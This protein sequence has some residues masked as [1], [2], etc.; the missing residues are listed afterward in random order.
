MRRVSAVSDFIRRRIAKLEAE[1]EVL[2]ATRDDLRARE[3]QEDVCRLT[4][5]HLGEDDPSF[6]RHLDVLAEIHR[7]LG[8]EPAARRCYEQAFG[9]LL[10]QVDPR[11]L[12]EE[13]VPSLPEEQGLE[14]ARQLN[15]LARLH[16]LLDRHEA[17]LGLL[18]KAL[19]LSRRQLGASHPGFAIL[20]H[21]LGEVYQSIGDLK[22]AESLYYQALKILGETLGCDH[23]EFVRSLSDLLSL[24]HEPED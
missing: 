18:H 5:W 23:P 17:A 24:V 13:E 6:V 1:V 19:V 14:A 7:R 20:V 9:R 12:T 4:G 2:L 21:N 8:D 16:W 10:R 11:L 22:K 15:R 3:L